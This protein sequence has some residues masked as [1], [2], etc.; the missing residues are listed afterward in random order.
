MKLDQLD[1]VNEALKDEDRLAGDEN[2]MNY[3]IK[4]EVEEGEE[5]KAHE[6]EGSTMIEIN[7]KDFYEFDEAESTLNR[8]FAISPLEMK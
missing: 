5:R 4:P 6:V 1:K 2:L 3:L 7:A 8:T